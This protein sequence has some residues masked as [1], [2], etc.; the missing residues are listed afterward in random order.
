MQGLNSQSGEKAQ[1]RANA[2]RYWTGGGRLMIIALLRDGLL[3]V[4]PRREMAQPAGA[5]GSV[6]L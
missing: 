1:T 6:Y 2:K 4:R 5:F 3:A